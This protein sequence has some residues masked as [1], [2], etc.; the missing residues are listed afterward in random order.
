MIT[1]HSNS[2]NSLSNAFGRTNVHSTIPIVLQ[3]FDDQR[4]TKSSFKDRP[5]NLPVSNHRP[6]R[7]SHSPIW[8]TMFSTGVSLFNIDHGTVPL[9]LLRLLLLLLFLLLL[10]LLLLFL[11]SWSNIRRMITTCTVA[12]SVVR[13]HCSSAPNVAK[14]KTIDGEP[15]QRC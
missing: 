7:E 9:L 1:I 8:T 15:E 14:W 3:R 10:P 11:I 12:N 5:S 6:L 2:S 4:C 13:H